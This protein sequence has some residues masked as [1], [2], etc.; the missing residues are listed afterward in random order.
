MGTCYCGDVEDEHE[1]GGGECLVEGCGCVA[2]D[3]DPE[4]SAG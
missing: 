4:A 1:E 2:Y 3:E